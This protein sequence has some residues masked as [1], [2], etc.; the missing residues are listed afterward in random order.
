MFEAQDM[1][2]EID[3]EDEKAFSFVPEAIITKRE[4]IVLDTGEENDEEDKEKEELFR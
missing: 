4:K 2:G 3:E 1:K